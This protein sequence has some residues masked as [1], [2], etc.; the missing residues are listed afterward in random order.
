[1]NDSFLT[2]LGITTLIGCGLM[3][4]LWGHA[5]IKR[6][7][8][9]VD[10]AWSFILGLCGVFYA[11]VA[12][13]DPTRRILL[14]AIVGVWSL[15]LTAYLFIDRVMKAK[16][17]DGRYQELRARWGASATRNFF[18][19]FQAQALLAVLLSIPFLVAAR[20]TSPAWSVFDFAAAALWIV[21]IVGESIADRQLAAWRAN[22]ANKGRT[23]RAGLWNYSR[24][25]NYFFEW[26]MWCSYATLALNALRDDASWNWWALSAWLAPAL[27]LYLIFNVTGIPPT[28]A[29]ALRTRGGDYRRYQREVSPFVPWFPNTTSHSTGAHNRNPVS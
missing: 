23:C 8:S 22:P 7:A 26:L 9:V 15:R 11:A 10:V 4:A 3:V 6:D 29:R 19:F 16:E 2:P 28:E 21:G 24:H 25:P 12:D 14:A 13:G 5:T 27:M 1:M 20:A 18:L 17:E